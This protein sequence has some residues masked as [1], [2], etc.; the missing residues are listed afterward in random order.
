MRNGNEVQ[1]ILG[2]NEVYLLGLSHFQDLIL[3]MKIRY[4]LTQLQQLFDKKQMYLVLKMFKTT[5]LQKV[6][7]VHVRNC[8]N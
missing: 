5:E 6:L 4:Q 2:C 3:Q 1:Y 8:R 7:F